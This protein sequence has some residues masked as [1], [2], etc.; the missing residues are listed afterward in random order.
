MPFQ[1]RVEVNPIGATTGEDW[2][3][4]VEVEAGVNRDGRG[5]PRRCIRDLM[6]Q[7]HA[8][9]LAILVDGVDAT[10]SRRD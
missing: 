10:P 5:Q 8:S 9:L 2:I 4:P 7:L 1:A 6:S 3:P